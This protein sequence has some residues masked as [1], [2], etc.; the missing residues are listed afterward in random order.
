MLNCR[1]DYLPPPLQPSEVKAGASSPRAGWISF[2]RIQHWKGPQVAC[3]AWRIL[4]RKAPDL[5][6]YGRTMNHGE[7]GRS[8]SEWLKGSFP[9]VWGNKI[10]HHD[11]VSPSEVSILMAKAKV[12]LVPSLWDTF[13]YVTVEAMAHGCVVLVSDGAGAAD[14]IEH[15]QNG[16]VFKNENAEELASLVKKI[17]GLS[18]KKT[19]KIC[20]AASKKIIKSLNPSFIAKQ[21]IIYYSK[22]KIP[23]DHCNWLKKFIIS[24]KQNSLEEYNYFLN[25]YPIK[26]L[27][28]Q[29]LKRFLKAVLQKHF[30]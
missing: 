30:F 21:K 2:G 28:K 22:Q 5:D 20:L 26:I 24:N 11:P 19:T 8:L 27:L 9:D 14:L 16:F 1:V 3:E 18:D 15:G 7:S 25:Q 29:I 23:K 17:E 12:V 13:N 4:G 6:W 10:V